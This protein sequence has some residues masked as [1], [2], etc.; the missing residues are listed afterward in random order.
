M[1]TAPQTYPSPGEGTTAVP[2]PATDT[3]PGT[4]LGGPPIP[5]STDPATGEPVPAGTTL[6]PDGT[7]VV[8]DADGTV[9]MPETPPD[10]APPRRPA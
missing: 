2:A 5:I 10:K 4:Y 1:A 6:E 3:A 9:V 7:V 8:P